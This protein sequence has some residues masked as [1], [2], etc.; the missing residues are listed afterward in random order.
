M[1]TGE[2]TFWIRFRGPCIAARCIWIKPCPLFAK[3]HV[4]HIIGQYDETNGEFV[5][6]LRV[7]SRPGWLRGAQY[8]F[9]GVEQLVYPP[10]GCSVSSNPTGELRSL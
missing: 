1:H 8:Q 3:R 10:V 2:G 5:H 7:V 4:L 9:M 6:P